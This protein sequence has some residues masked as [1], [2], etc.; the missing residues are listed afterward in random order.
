MHIG[1]IQF[2]FVC[3]LWCT[4]NHLDVQKILNTYTNTHLKLDLHWSAP[5]D[6]VLLAGGVPVRGVEAG[7]GGGEVGDHAA[8]QHALLH[9][10]QEETVRSRQS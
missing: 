4:K 2:L 10:A 8:L 9:P 1:E 7:A 3:Y 5:V 6:T